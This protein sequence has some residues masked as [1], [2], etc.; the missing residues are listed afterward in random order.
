[1]KNRWYVSLAPIFYLSLFL[2][3][4]LFPERGLD[5]IGLHAIL[6]SVFTLVFLAGTILLAYVL[7]RKILRQ[8]ATIDLTVLEALI[9]YL[10]IGLGALAYGVL[11]LALAGWLNPLAISLWLV[12][13]V[14]WTWRE[15]NIVMAD[16]LLNLTNLPLRWKV[17]ARGPK[18]IVIAAGLI[19]VTTL[20]H[21]LTPPWDYDGLM[22][23]LQAPRLFLEA[24][25]I[26]LLP[27]IWQA[28]GPLTT[29]M[30]FAIGLA[31]GSDSFAKLI[32]LTYGILLVLAT[33]TFGRRYFPNQT[34]WIALAILLGIP[35]LPIWASW[36][37]T[38]FAWAAYEF[39]GVYALIFWITSH[40]RRWLLIA[41]LLCGLALGSKYLALGSTALMY[42]WILWHSRRQTITAIITNIS[43]FGFCAV[44]TASPWYI[45][46]MIFSGNLFFP[47]VFGGPG[48][49]IPRLD[50]LTDY[51]RSFGA[52]KGILD[53]LLL[54][55]NIFVRHEMFSTLSIE[56]P[57]LLFPLALLYPLVRQGK[58]PNSAALY[59]FLWCGIWAV[60]SQQ[61]R[62][63]LPVF[64]FFA[65]LTASVILSIDHFR[66]GRVLMLGLIGGMVATTLVYQGLYFVQKQPLG[67]VLG[68]ESKAE[69]LRRY[70]Y[71][72]QAME[73]LN[74][75]L[76]PGDRVLMMWDG[77]S[78]YCKTDCLPDTDQTR[79][80]RLIGQKPT[81]ESVSK[82]LSEM[83]VTH[84]FFSQGDFA[85]FSKYHDPSGM[86]RQ[87]MQY[88]LEVFQDACTRDIYHD[89]YVTIYE[90]TCLD[91]VE[92]K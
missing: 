77:N 75:N 5:E 51:L 52:G 20:I 42:M 18:I 85:W 26:F 19:L 63:L 1:M 2:L 25:R 71:D 16:F 62:F 30:L 39:L 61:T 86:H 32:H 43:L 58:I 79:W 48:W 4:I 44:I 70:V 46:N 88:F 56:I 17:I 12:I 45:K 73:Y 65:L 36:A 3:R 76:R 47:F 90:L 10:A 40:K 34:A 24:G 33:F 22:Y 57:G 67:V 9:F 23:H 92:I 81:V 89:E 15:W 31:Y 74:N 54:P 7:G 50:M 64:P 55:L 27:E 29:E 72:Y 37:Y 83:N 84:L 68:I 8:I 41:G 82:K 66:W 35:V 6:D 28:N 78:Y 49:D 87:A 13:A 60:G 53:Y 38:D 69:Y 59:T 91:N 11:F 80:L 14:C 21:A